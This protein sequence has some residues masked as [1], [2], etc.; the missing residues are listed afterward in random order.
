MTHLKLDHLRYLRSQ[1]YRRER[2]ARLRRLIAEEPHAVSQ[3]TVVHDGDR[4]CRR[5]AWPVTYA[6][7]LAALSADGEGVLGVIL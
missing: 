2:H 5:E 7:L 4:C 6:A 1:V 3:M